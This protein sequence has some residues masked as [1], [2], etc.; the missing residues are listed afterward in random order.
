MNEASLDPP[1]KP[2][3]ALLGR[4]GSHLGRLEPQEAS[5]GPQIENKTILKSIRTLLRRGD[6][7]EG[8]ECCVGRARALSYLRP[9]GQ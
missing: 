4:I 7:S 9:E 2:P 8:E 3:V 6:F 5:S 1:G